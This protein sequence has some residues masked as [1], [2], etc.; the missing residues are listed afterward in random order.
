M[1]VAARLATIEDLGD[2]EVLYRSL[3]AEMIALHP[4]W[5]LADGL[6]EPITE[7]LGRNLLDP[8]VVLVLGTIDELPFG[9]L[10]ARIEPLLPQAEGLRFGAIRLVFVDHPAREVGVGEAML[11]LALTEMR[12]R[13]LVRFDAHVLPG[14]RL[15][16]NFFEAGGFAARSIIMHHVDR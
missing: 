5:P 8:E 2:L 4:M 15:V 13:G 11:A 10:L 12:A 6:A 1:E 9:F 14:H 16:K 7:S 3:E